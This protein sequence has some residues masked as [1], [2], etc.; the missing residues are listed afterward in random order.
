LIAGEAFKMKT[1]IKKIFPQSFYIYIREKV[2]YTRLVKSYLYDLNHYFKYSMNIEDNAEGK[3]ISKIILDTHVIEKGLTMP[4]PKLGF[5]SARLNI[6]ID[7][8]LLCIHYHS[9]KNPQLTH[10][11]SVLQEYYDFHKKY[12][13]ELP[14]KDIKKFNALIRL[15][16][17]K[18]ISV[19]QRNQLSITRDEYFSQAKGD[20]LQFSQSRSSIRN[21]SDKLIS[22]EILHQAI[23]LA[24]NTPSACN[25]QAVRVHLY[26]DKKMI[27]NILAIQGGNRGFGHLAEF[28]I[29][30]T[31]KPDVYFEQGERNSGHVDGGMY[32]MNMLYALHAN[33]LAACVLNAAHTPEKDIKIRTVS[34]IPEDEVFVTFIVGG[35]PPEKF[36]IARSYRY[37]LEHILTQHGLH[38]NL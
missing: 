23:D 31:F 3:L 16:E 35:I 36:N 12:D 20:F 33:K 14:E 37:P 18:S 4:E 17:S 15:K 38:D 13:F 28:L 7:N 34:Y 2:R 6:L 26:Q 21:Y 24:R 19:T 29:A 9:I 8:I 5:G 22:D 1:L 25:R 10:A 11:L 27:S 32:S 30:I